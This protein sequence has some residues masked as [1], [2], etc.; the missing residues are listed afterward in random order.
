MAATGD[1]ASPTAGRGR[2]R[3]GVGIVG[4]D[5]GAAHA[6]A[7]Q[8]SPARYTHCRLRGRRRSEARTRSPTCGVARCMGR[9]VVVAVACRS[10]T[11]LTRSP[12]PRSPRGARAQ[13]AD[14]RA[15]M[16]KAASFSGWK[17]LQAS[18]GGIT[19]AVDPLGLAFLSADAPAGTVPAALADESWR[20]P[21][22]SVRGAPLSAV[23]GVVQ[24]I[25]GG[26]A[27]R[28][29]GDKCARIP[30]IPAAVLRRASARGRQAE[31]R[32][33]HGGEPKGRARDPTQYQGSLRPRRIRDPATLNTD[34]IMTAAQAP[35]PALTS[36]AA[37]P[38]FA[39]EP[40][41]LAW[42][43]PATS[44][45]AAGKDSTAS[46][47]GASAATSGAAG[48]GATDASSGAPGPASSPCGSGAEPS[49]CPRSGCWSGRSGGAGHSWSRHGT[50]PPQWCWHSYV[51][52]QSQRSSQ[53]AGSIPQTHSSHPHPWHRGDDFC[54]H[55][56]P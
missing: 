50:Q 23:A 19:A 29:I 30:S 48:S 12:D 11:V 51:H 53:H 14:S 49:A 34:A 36:T 8:P 3:A 41:G 10:A 31:Y 35:T 46:A 7:A 24:A 4:D 27:I 28:R 21:A 25:Q 20:T 54:T 17:V 18:L 40:P 56:Y 43:G 47:E 15:W 55:P 2:S 42:S 16:T 5:R 22:V 6:S 26:V 39:A 33:R 52:F 37:A 44:A 13:P 9:S 45:S 32:N 38:Q 1:V